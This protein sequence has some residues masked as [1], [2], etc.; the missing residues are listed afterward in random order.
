MELLKHLYFVGL[1][2][3]TLKAVPFI[4]YSCIV[5]CCYRVCGDS[6]GVQPEVR[7]G[8][9]SQKVEKLMAL[10]RE[11]V[12]RLDRLTCNSP[13]SSKTCDGMDNKGTRAL[14]TSRETSAQ[15]KSGLGESS[16]TCSTVTMHNALN[17]SNIY[18]STD[19]S[20]KKTHGPSTKGNILSQLDDLHSPSIT[21][22]SSSSDLCPL[23][24]SS[25]EVYARPWTGSPKKQPSSILKKK[26]VD[27]PYPLV[28]SSSVPQ[29]MPV[30]I[31]KRKT[32][33]DEAR[34]V[35]GGSLAPPPPVTFSPS[36]LDQAG[37]G[38]K[39]QGILKK[40]SSL[41]ESQVLRRR[42][43]SPDMA[44]WDHDSSSE[45]RPILKNQRRSSMEELV[46]RTQ[47]PDPH[48]QSILKRRT[49]HEDE[50]EERISG[51]PEPQGILKR[52][53]ATSSNSSSSSTSPHISIAASVIMNVAGWG[54]DSDILPPDGGADHVRPILKKKSSSE[55]NNTGDSSSTEAPKPILKKK[56]SVE[57]DDVE[58]RP[59]KPI[60][61]SS[62][63]SSQEEQTSWETASMDSPVRCLILRSRG[64][65]GSDSAS[66]S[67]CEVVRPILKQPGSD[68]SSRERSAS[69][70]HRL[71]FC[72][73]QD[74]QVVKTERRD[75]M[76]SGKGSDESRNVSPAG[77]GAIHQRRLKQSSVAKS[78]SPSYMD[79]ELGAILSK[80]R[81]LEVT[82]PTDVES[83]QLRRSPV[84]METARGQPR[85][86]S[87]A[88][89][90]LTMENFLCQEMGSTK[91]TGAVPKKPGSLRA[92][93]DRERFR[94]QPIT[95]HEL[96]ASA[97]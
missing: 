26:S 90:I 14:H 52:K 12:A 91:Q 27:E 62:R 9:V 50:V 2:V 29:Q 32:S 19:S 35:S 49:S 93:R 39:R 28:V 4:C 1:P 77:E 43:C 25:N 41:D 87:V 36:V 76:G 15:H 24:T 45:F 67:D 10:T 31:L 44:A 38:G 34:S 51:S 95:L 6:S 65:G 17:R 54:S 7:M 13:A 22:K 72:D 79:N 46:R 58:E 70:R 21:I 81:S 61:K 96:S 66:G 74:Q 71:S 85:P 53:S 33:Q 78:N 30:S 84:V 57:V 64:A 5:L 89:R 16:S 69:P 42:S 80:R 40:R 55:D 20:V 23:E 11:T 59:M 82:M 56:S 8:S 73:D 48:P 18:Q 63:K 86:M 92:P 88:E 75:S 3:I 60:L 68:R 94:T 37:S 97:G 83:I 47:S